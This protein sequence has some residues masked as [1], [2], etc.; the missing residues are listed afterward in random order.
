MATTKTR[1]KSSS[2]GVAARWGS[3]GE[4]ALDAMSCPPASRCRAS[5]GIPAIV[6]DLKDRI[7]ASDGVLLVTPEYNSS[8]PGVFKNAIDWLTRPAS[9]IA[10]VFNH[11][12]VGVIG[13]TPGRGGTILAQAVAGASDARDE[14]L[15]R[16]ANDRQWSEARVRRKRTARRRGNTVTA[17]DLHGGIRRIHREVASSDSCQSA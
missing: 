14:T 13:A 10:R 9:D 7:A 6:S 1:S 15:V 5:A 17:A 4:R 3:C 12:P 11:R 8:I 16:R 2:R